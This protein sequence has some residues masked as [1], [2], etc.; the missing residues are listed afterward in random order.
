MKKVFIISVINIVF[1]NSVY[2]QLDSVIYNLQQ[3]FDRFK[4]DIEQEHRQFKEKNDSVFS[5]FLKDSWE[6]FEVF[7]K[8]IEEP[9]KPV[10]Q[11]EVKEEKEPIPQEITPE[12]PDSAKNYFFSPEKPGD[13]HGKIPFEPSGKSGKAMLNFNFY[14]TKTTALHPGN[15]PPI[16]SINADNIESYFKATCNMSSIS[17]LIQGLWQTKNKLRLNDWGYYKLVEQAARLAEATTSRQTLFAW[18]ILLK[19]GYNVKAGF[20]DDDIF[21]MLP[22][23]QEIFS[24]YYLTIDNTPYYIQTKRGK[25]DPLP[26]LQV[27]KANYPE[28]T[29]LSLRLTEIPLLENNPLKKNLLFKGDTIK[30]NQNKWLADFYN[31]YPHCEMG[32]YFSA[33]LSKNIIEPLELYFNLQFIGNT[34]QE[35]VTLLLNFVQNTFSYKTDMEQFGREKYFFP[36]EVFYYPFSD[37][38]DR[39]ILF[40]RLVKYFTNYDCVGLDYPGHVNTAVNFNEEI[41]GTYINLEDKKYI[42]CDPTYVNAPIGYLD[43]KYESLQPKII[44]SE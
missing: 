44:I 11:P 21:L 41:N 34:D 43:S 40:A 39:S 35:K 28:N 27:H 14:G 31:E 4:Q 42:V 36:D 19:S 22:F 30:I 33:P 29:K 17:E 16:E 1:F 7:Y 38:E 26:R 10:V 6:E 3:E 13:I 2:A 12:P 20:T 18:V 23:H 32:V 9:P 37:C 5:K 8:E 15:L 25:N 24:I